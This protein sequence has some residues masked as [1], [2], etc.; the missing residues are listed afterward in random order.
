MLTEIHLKNVQIHKEL[1][2]KLTKNL[3]VICGD[4]G[5]GKS[6][7]IRAFKL[8]FENQ[9]R[10]GE[11]DLQR[12]ESNK[13]VKDQLSISI[14]DDKG[15][16]IIRT[17][18]TYII[19]NGKP[20][21][22]IG[23]DIPEPVKQIMPLSKVNWQEQF[24]PHFLI[25][26]TGGI[27]AKQ[28]N[29][30]TGMESQEQILQETKIRINIQKNKIKNLYDL[31]EQIKIKLNYLSKIN[32]H[33]I[34]A[35]DINNL[36]IELQEYNSQISYLNNSIE[37]LEEL[38]KQ[39]ALRS[40]LE[41]NIQTISKIQNEIK[42]ITQTNIIINDLN[43]KII[44][45]KNYKQLSSKIKNIEKYLKQIDDLFKEQKKLNEINSTIVYLNN[46]QKQFK[47]NKIEYSIAISDHIKAKALFNT[48]LK[49][50]GICPLCGIKIEGNHL[51]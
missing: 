29:K 41:K 16:T 27:A 1:K 2:I 50:Y 37:E 26:Q 47:Q 10:S 25:L 49:N 48:T 12:R 15:N 18:R 17:N 11:N 42:D 35:D 44:E 46:N 40:L 36:I 20:L 8:L 23:T 30:F 4:S 34:K 39:Q 7:L 28:L 19:N 32:P 31:N 14:K 45:L 3:N 5:E 22:A 21:K 6:A 43:N 51:C 13:E 9:P 38:N 33:K 24:D